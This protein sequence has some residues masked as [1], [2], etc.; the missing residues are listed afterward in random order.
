MQVQVLLPVFLIVQCREIDTYFFTQMCYA[1][2]D[3]GLDGGRR[4]GSEKAGR[5]SDAGAVF[6]Y[7]ECSGVPHS[8]LDDHCSFNQPTTCFCPS[9]VKGNAADVFSESS[10]VSKL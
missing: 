2:N 7:Q 1:I 4:H 3:I 8:F 5:N 10:V 9:S 6:A